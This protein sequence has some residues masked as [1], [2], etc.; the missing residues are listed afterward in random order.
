MAATPRPSSVIETGDANDLHMERHARAFIRIRIPND[1]PETMAFSV[2]KLSERPGYRVCRTTDER[3]GSGP[4][5]NVRFRCR[6]VRF[7]SETRFS[8]G[9]TNNFPN[10]T[11][12]IF[13]RPPKW[14]R[15][16]FESRLIPRLNE[17]ETSVFR[18]NVIGRT[19][20]DWVTGRR[21]LYRRAVIIVRELHRFDYDSS[22]DIRPFT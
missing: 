15:P 20:V 2:I 5:C 17:N 4:L 13:Y 8:N 9:P 1:R 16:W 14:L 12:V 18:L 6:T 7:G 3:L 11:S 22:M 10:E 19:V 21:R